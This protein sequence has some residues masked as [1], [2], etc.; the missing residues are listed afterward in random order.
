[1]K[2]LEWHERGE[3]S[4]DPID[5][6]SNYWRGFNNLYASAGIGQE[7]EKI[8]AFL[9][10]RV[11]EEQATA[12]LTAN[13]DCI[14]YLVSEPTVDMRGNGKDTAPNIAAYSAAS[15]ALAKLEQVLLVIYQV[16]CNLE[17]GQKSP[18]RQRDIELCKCSAP[19]VAALIKSEA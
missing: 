17:H 19:I 9:R 5:A 12:V 1:M 4:A 6:L 8:V 3:N 7:R 15:T 13:A 18:S 14:T 2:A 11:T 10:A 16:R